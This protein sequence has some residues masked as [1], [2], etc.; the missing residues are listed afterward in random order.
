MLDVILLSIIATFCTVSDYNECGYMII[1]DDDWLDIIYNDYK[2]IFG[3][4]ELKPNFILNGFAMDIGDYQ[5]IYIS[6][7]GLHIKPDYGCTVMWHEL[8]HV[9]LK[10]ATA[11]EEHQEMAER[12]KCGK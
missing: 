10:M 2:N 4:N 5:W 12:F 6:E 1:V 11:E 8:I 3:W 9:E 7:S